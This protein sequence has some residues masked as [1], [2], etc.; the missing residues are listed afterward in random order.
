MFTIQYILFIYKQV[1][2]GVQMEVYYRERDF[3]LLSYFVIKIH[4]RKS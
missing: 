4:A 2:T 1:V 3:T